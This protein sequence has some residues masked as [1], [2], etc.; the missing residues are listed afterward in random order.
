MRFKSFQKRFKSKTQKMLKKR[1]N[2][3]VE[4]KR[5]LE[6]AISTLVLLV[7]GIFLLIGLITILIMGW[8]DFKL[9]VSAIMGSDAAKAEKTCK[10]QCGLENNYDFCCDIKKI[11]GEEYNCKDF[12][13][14][15][16]DIKCSDVICQL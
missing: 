4:D 15:E 3:V 5:G 12:S 1:V 16:C 13:A 8:D 7:L 2:K 6:M 11:K 9:N 14:V 10:L